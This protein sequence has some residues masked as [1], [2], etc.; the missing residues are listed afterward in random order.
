MSDAPPRLLIRSARSGA[1]RGHKKRRFRG[2]EVE[3]AC[4]LQSPEA[5]EATGDREERLV[6]LVPAVVADEQPLEVMEQAKVRSTTQRARP[7]PEPCAIWRRAI[8]GAIPCCAARADT[9]H[10]RS[11][12]RRSHARDDASACRPCRAPAAPRSR[13][14]RR[15]DGAWSRLWLDQ[16]GSGPSRSP[17][18]RLPVT[19]I[20]D[21]PRPSQFAGCAQLGAQR[22][23]ELLPRACLLPL[24]QAAAAGRSRAEPELERQMPPSDSCVQHEQDPCSA[25]RS[26]KRLRP[27]KRKRR[28]TFGNSGSIRSHNR[29]DTIHG[30]TT[31]GAPPSSLTTDADGMTSAWFVS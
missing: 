31:I 19:G 23:V 20:G 15:G 11:R 7:S 16:P 5:D 17:L 26:G 8:S 29:S 21:R 27:G 30:A 13:C 3:S 14:H 1:K 28:S 25:C 10:G 12:G 18:F 24:V 2:L 4:L 22:S 9:C 6:D